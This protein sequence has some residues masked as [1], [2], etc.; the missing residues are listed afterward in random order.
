MLYHQARTDFNAK[1]YQKMRDEIR[2]A[3][4]ELE[5]IGWTQVI[6]DQEEGAEES[7]NLGRST[8]L[9]RSN[10]KCREKTTESE[11]DIRRKKTE[12]SQEPTGPTGQSPIGRRRRPDGSRPLMKDYTYT[13]QAMLILSS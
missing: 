9:H 2:M 5:E 6:S 12:T 1:G 8:R 4:E 7:A 11:G 10:S 3:Y 13:R